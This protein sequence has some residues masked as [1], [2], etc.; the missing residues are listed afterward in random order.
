MDRR[1]VVFGMLG[2]QLDAGAGPGRWEKWRP[3]VSLG[4]HEDFLPD[5][6]EL[7]VDQR[8]FGKLAALVREDLALVS[9]ETEVR[10]HDTYL[11]DPWE[12]E[13]VYACLHD[14]LA[15]YPFRPEE[16]DYYIHITTGTHVSQICWF[17]LTESRHFPGRLLQTAPPRKQN[18]KDPGMYAV[19]DLDL[20]RYDRIAQRFHQ[21]QLQD[22]DLLKSGIATRNPAFNRMIEQIETVAT[23][24]RAP[25]LLTG[26]T[27]AGKSQLAKRVFELKKLKHQLPGRFVEVN[28][29]TLRGDG[30]MST[31][32]GHVKGAY[33]GASGDRAGLL[34]SAHQGL[35]FLDEIGELGL[36]EQAMLLR[37]LE[38]KRFLPVGSDR[39]VESDFQLIAGTN[40]DLQDA[41]LQGRFREDL[42]ARLNLWTYRLP[43]L[44]ERA[45]DIEPNLEFELERW[46]REQHQRVAFNREARARYL[47]FATGPEA[48]WQGNFRDLSASIM[49]LATLANA[50]RIQLQG[51][52][53]EIARLRG[54]WRGGTRPSPLD[55]L[56]GEAA[57]RL[58]RFDRVQLEEVV[59]VC[60]RSRSLSAAGRELFAVSRSQRASTNDADRLRKYLAR[61][62]LD[63]EQVRRPSDATAD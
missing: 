40:R 26:P 42:L 51:V 47:A 49:R 9:P 33:T 7:L 16:E 56:L 23:R 8:R 39:E 36:D 55:A 22:R 46:S 61:F 25:M 58:D 59:R 2:T 27:G 54:Q 3:T 44:A 17:L 31:L 1:Q 62:G 29:A 4:M 20:S 12:F 28:C 18:G 35:L 30:A 60:A 52:E 10:L 45:E 32:F 63:W 48:T 5:R 13:G 41:V 19:I 38:E 57:D 21:Q 34:R 6:F 24:S 43:G 11:A 15:G 53:E 14:F 50:G 37:A